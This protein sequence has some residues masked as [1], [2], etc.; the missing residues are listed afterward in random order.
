[1][2]AILLS[3]G[4]GTRL[5]P[6]TTELPKPMIPLFGRPLLEHLL[7]LLRRSGVTEAAVTLHCMPEVIRAWFG[8]GSDWGMRLTYLT[9]DTPLGTAGSVKACQSFLEGEEDFLVL[10]A[11]C[12]CDFDLASAIAAH[13]EAGAIATLLLHKAANPLEYGLVHTDEGGR[14]LR[15]VEKPGWSQV[16]T[17]RINTGIYL[18]RRDILD[19]IPAGEASDFSLDLFPRLLE[20]DIPLQTQTPYGYWRDVGTPEALLAAVRDA[21]DGKVKLDMGL[22]QRKGGVWSEEPLPERVEVL[23]PC[24]IGPGVSLGQGAMIGPH[25][26][27][28]QGSS[29]GK[30]AAVQG[31]LVL[32]AAIGDGAAATGAI[33]CRGSSL[34]KGAVMADHTVLG[35][36]AVAEENAILHPGVKVWPGLRVAAGARLNASLTAGT[37]RGQ[38]LFGDD[39]TL[40]GKL[41]IDLT[42]ELLVTVGS[43]LGSEGRVGLGG[44]GG[45]GCQAL[46]RAASAGI[47]AAG[48]DVFLHDGTT[49]LAAAWFARSAAVPLSLF[50]EQ[51]GEDVRM[52]CLDGDGLPFSRARQRRLEQGLL[53]EAVYRAAPGQIGTERVTGGVD[54]SWLTDA[55]RSVAASPLPKV[56]VIVSHNG[57]ENR[58]L[59]EG[60]TLL[61]VTVEHKERKGIPVFRLSTEGTLS[62]IDEQGQPIGGEQ[63]L[64]LVL[65]ILMERGER[66]LAAPSA[67]PASAEK[68]A[69][70]FGGKLYRL[71]RDGC[72]GRDCYAAHPALWDGVYAACL[73][74]SHMGRTGQGLNRLVATLPACAVCRTE[75]RLEHSRGELMRALGEK[76]PH[77]EHMPD[78]LRFAVGSG[79]VWITPLIRASALGIAAEAAD[80]EMAEELCALVREQTKEL[81]GKG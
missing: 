31:S 32:G 63:L 75:V 59:A 13:R 54:R 51:R 17:N 47:T 80:S 78:G 44:F 29:V 81:D 43:I 73:I 68:L 62:A 7:L 48:G 1:M 10:P 33:L 37:S 39:G 2:K 71:A 52:H 35:E 4:Q 55:A 66:A 57:L 40:S 60:L 36:D 79:S 30:R 42:P 24:W 27:L 61:G 53:R 50:L 20:E 16:F 14:V 67:A 64:L 49:A 41:G 76:Y 46:L 70:Q 69:E 23:P 26:L 38:M 21:L 58:L 56:T 74:C 28:E 72:A 11:D 65:A 6:V 9:E 3:G 45:S 77:A 12:V 25:T 34:G 5:R 22:P 19:H 18:F 15:F 8:D